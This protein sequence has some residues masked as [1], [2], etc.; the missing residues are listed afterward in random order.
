MLTIVKLTRERPVRLCVQTHVHI[1][2]AV[3]LNAS[4]VAFECRGIICGEEQLRSRGVAADDDEWKHC[5]CVVVREGFGHQ[6]R[7]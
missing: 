4:E 6:Q 7:L 1:K 5:Q 3:A 2:E